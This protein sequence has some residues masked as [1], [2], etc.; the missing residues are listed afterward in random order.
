LWLVA[1]GSL[2]LTVGSSGL[3]LLALADS[4]LP[5]ALRVLMVTAGG[6]CAAFFGS[7]A[8]VIAIDARRG[9]P[10]LAFDDAT[11]TYYSVATGSITIPWADVTGMRITAVGPPLGQPR[12]F[13]ALDVEDPVA[14]LNKLHLARRVL[15]RANLKLGGGLFSI[16]EGSIDVPLESLMETLSDAQ[17]PAHQERLRAAQHTYTHVDPPWRSW[18]RPRR[19]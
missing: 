12:R 17:G 18:R 2:A 16:F 5:L 19:T 7:M 10:V 6:M 3:L 15:A 9:R 13:L 1:L 11:I 14:V 8:V 4:S